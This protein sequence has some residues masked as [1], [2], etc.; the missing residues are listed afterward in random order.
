MLL[1]KKIERGDTACAAAVSGVRKPGGTEGQTRGMLTRAGEEMPRRR[2][3]TSLPAG[4][5]GG[6]AG[7][8]LRGMLK[9]REPGRKEEGGGGIPAAPGGRI[10]RRRECRRCGRR[11]FCVFLL[12]SV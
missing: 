1:H 7:R 3:R 11:V 2:E 5:E 10:L 12:T 4:R 8:L 6:E 9:P